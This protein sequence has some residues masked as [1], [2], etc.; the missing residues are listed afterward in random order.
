MNKFLKSTSVV[1]NALLKL[2]V[3]IQK[4]DLVEQSLLCRQQWPWRLR[5]VIYR[6]G[7]PLRMAVGHCRVLFRFADDIHYSAVCS[8]NEVSSKRLLTGRSCDR[9]RY[10]S[11]AFRDYSNKKCNW[12]LVFNDSF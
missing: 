5:E 2:S 6:T 12:I 4:V 10:W 3:V 7:H 11:L 1:S 9:T 8:R